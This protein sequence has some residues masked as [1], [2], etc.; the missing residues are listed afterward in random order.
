MKNKSLLLLILVTFFISINLLFSQTN[1][2]VEIT[3]KNAKIESTQT[4]IEVYQIDS[5][6][7][8]SDSNTDKMII[9][10]YP[11]TKQARVIYD[12]LY[13][14]YNYLDA[15]VALNKTL[16]SFTKK[17]KCYHFERSRNDEVHYCKLNDK[18][19]VRIIAF[20]NFYE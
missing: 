1:N 9:Y 3:N 11:V 14:T 15:F 5:D 8:Y 12:E 6:E 4:L 13:E 7:I 20:I 2:D 19:Y 18:D 10:Y 17:I 16:K